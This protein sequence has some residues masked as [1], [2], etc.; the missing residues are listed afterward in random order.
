VLPAPNNRNGI[1]VSSDL[2]QNRFL[3]KKIA[4]VGLSVKP[5][6]AVSRK[7][8]EVT[9]LQENA[10]PLEGW[11]RSMYGTRTMNPD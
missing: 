10:W 8:R 2:P 4:P 3:E 6:S 9:G 5:L 1:L 7:N 11:V